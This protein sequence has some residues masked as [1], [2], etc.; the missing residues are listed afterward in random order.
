METTTTT[1][2]EEIQ[3]HDFAVVKE[4]SIDVEFLNQL[5]ANKEVASEDKAKLRA[6]KKNLKGNKNGV[7]YKLGRNIKHEFLGRL[8][9]VKGVG[10]QS[11]SRNVRNA[12]AQKYYWDIDVVNA[13]PTL[14]LQI[15][16]KEGWECEHLKAYNTQREELLTQVVEKVGGTR[17]DAKQRVVSILFGQKP[18]GLP[19]FFM[20]EFY[21]EMRK[22]QENVWKTF[23]SKLKFLERVDN[24]VGKSMAHFL[25]TEE[26]RVLLAL[27]NALARR[28]RQGLDTLIHDGGLCLKLQDEENF[29]N[30]ILREVENDIKATGYSV[31]LAVKPMITLYTKEEEGAEDEEY[32][33]M[34]A[35]F[36]QTYFKITSPSIFCRN[37]Y[38]GLQVLTHK[39][40]I[41]Q[42]QQM[43][44]EDGSRFI[45]RWI[46]DENQRTY[47]RLTYKPKGD[48]EPNEYNLWTK[49]AVDPVA[50]AD[51]LAPVFRLRE[52]IS[53]YD[54]KVIWF[55]ER[56]LAT[57][58]Q[59]PWKKTDVCLVF[60]G[61]QGS[62]KDTFWDFVG[63]ILG[64]TYYFKTDSP[65]NNVMANF[66]TGTERCV[67][68]KFEEASYVT[69]KANAEKL[70]SKIT[71]KH[72]NYTKKGQDPVSL[73]D[74]R[75][76]VMTTNQQVPVHI[77]Q[78]DRRFML[79]ETANDK[80]G[81]HEFWNEI[82]KALANPEVKAA[83]H[84][85][86][87]SLDVSD[88]EPQRDRVK[89]AYYEQVKQAFTPTHARWFQ[90][91]VEQLL[92]NVADDDARDYSQ[93]YQA[94]TLFNKVKEFGRFE[95]TENQFGREMSKYV[96]GGALTKR[97]GNTHNE[98]TLDPHLMENYL[99]T[100]GWWADL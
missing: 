26:K 10:L 58:I 39:D 25:Q 48:V 75:N 99:K 61:E 24:R 41:H 18:Y 33:R 80:V 72:E 69:N 54:H 84:A 36:E 27:D 83:Y 76:F 11:L 64:E 88:F 51:L 68:V 93:T 32:N 37:T 59:T 15:C 70:K 98:Y 5:I 22:I 38:Y 47:E 77:E 90:R 53:N 91:E 6:I 19:E 95:M 62:G 9:A 63:G 89:T 16:E 55:I 85:H 13:Q 20:N 73:P 94:R 44:L 23:G 4:E 81:K 71:N 50:N 31:S 74:Y 86:L 92:H 21:T 40:L 3:S 87:M 14:L 96:A 30:G 49:F 79:V 97:Q 12:L 46:Q 43:G 35:E 67:L 8:C 66:N 2:T 17:A 34:K 100:K 60:S 52:V 56:W 7:T 28:G 42:T 45:N 65:E 82:H 78:T 57:I 29:P 1:Q